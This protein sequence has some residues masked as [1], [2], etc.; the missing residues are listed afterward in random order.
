MG[1]A[2][3]QCAI[4]IEESIFLPF[5]WRAQVRAAIPVEENLV[6]FFNGKQEGVGGLDAFRSAF[7]Y[8]VSVQYGDHC[9]CYSGQGLFK[10]VQ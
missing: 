2:L 9:L 6:V 4:G 3:D 8:I 1:R 5:Q 7:F 10:I